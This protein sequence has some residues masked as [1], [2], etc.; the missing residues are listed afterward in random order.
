MEG[1]EVGLIIPAQAFLNVFR[2]HVLDGLI[3]L[4]LRAVLHPLNR[5]LHGQLHSMLLDAV[6]VQ[7]PEMKERHR[8]CWA[9]VVAASVIDELVALFGVLEVEGRHAEVAG[10]WIAKSRVKPVVE[11][12][13]G[14]MLNIV[15]VGCQDDFVAVVLAVTVFCLLLDRESRLSVAFRLVAANAGVAVAVDAFRHCIGRDHGLAFAFLLGG[16]LASVVLP[17]VIFRGGLSRNRRLAVVVRRSRDAGVTK[18]VKVMVSRQCFGRDQFGESVD[19]VVEEALLVRIDGMAQSF[20]GTVAMLVLRVF[21]TQERTRVRVSLNLNMSDLLHASMNRKIAGNISPRRGDGRSRCQR[22]CSILFHLGFHV[23]LDDQ[24]LLSCLLRLNLGLHLGMLARA[25]TRAAGRALSLRS[26]DFSNA[27]RSK[28]SGCLK[29]NGACQGER[30]RF[31]R[32]CRGKRMCAAQVQSVELKWNAPPHA[33]DRPMEKEVE[34]FQGCVGGRAWARCCR[35]CVGVVRERHAHPDSPSARVTLED[36]RRKHAA[37]GSAP[38]C[39]SLKCLI[40]VSFRP[41]DLPQK[42]HT[43][44]IGFSLCVTLAWRTREVLWSKC[45]SQLGH[46]TEALRR[47]RR[48]RR[49]PPP[50]LFSPC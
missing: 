34:K 45:L 38:S 39:L 7:A 12:S 27:S 15:E 37:Y 48:L 6:N 13:L 35:C 17:A 3:L 23:E 30:V 29:A 1:D 22:A 21:E 24:L 28:E 18:G 43:G 14:G 19:T 42:R 41:N 20:Q 40:N 4:H 9:L 2:L 25:T 46:G 5:S 47:L 49:I 11:A 16:E 31:G 8:T 44:R 50:S 26:H 10:I 33:Q 32:G 36:R